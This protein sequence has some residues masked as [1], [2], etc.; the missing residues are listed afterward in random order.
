M[1][2]THHPHATTSHAGK[3]PE[4]KSKDKHVSPRLSHVRHGRHILNLE[5][6]HQ[7]GEVPTVCNHSDHLQT[8]ADALHSL[9]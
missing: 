7:G 6:A 8:A 2:V 1:F 4:L 9:L 3:E 5:L